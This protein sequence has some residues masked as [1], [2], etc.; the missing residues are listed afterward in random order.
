MH[1]TSRKYSRNIRTL[2]L[3]IG[4]AGGPIPLSAAEPQAEEIVVKAKPES[5]RE[6]TVVPKKAR[7]SDTASLLADEPGVAVQGAGGVSSLP[8]VHG[9]AD[10]RVLVYVDGMCLIASCPNHMN[11][12]L[13]YLDPSQVGE[14]KVYAGISPVSLGGDSIGGTIVARTPEP[15][16]ADKGER[17]VRGE[18]GSY[19]RSNGSARGGNLSLGYATD[20][21]NITYRGAIARMDDYSAGKNFK[22]TT[23]T[24][25]PGETLP[26]DVVGSTA[27][28]TQNQ[29]LGLALRN[30]DDLYDATMGYQHVPFQLYPN[31]RMDMLN[32]QA[33]RLNLHYTGKKSWG[34][35]E[36]RLYGE[37]VDH[38]MDFGKDK[39]FYYGTAPNIAPGMPMFTKSKTEGARINADIEMSKRDLLRIGAE[40]QLYRLD[41]W[42]PPSPSVLQGGVTFSG[43]AP[44]TFWNINGGKRDRYGVFSEW[45]A[46]WN[47]EWMTLLGARVELVAMDT[48]TVQGYNSV[49]NNA[50]YSEGYLVSATKF[51]ALDRKRNDVNLDLTALTRYIPDDQHTYEVGVAQKTRTPNLYERYVW[52]RNTMALVM[53]NF[54]GDGNGY[55]GNPDLKPEVA[56]TISA[57]A[58]L[59]SSDKR[60]EIKVAPYF[61]HVSD[62]ID[63]VQWNRTTNVAGVNTPGQ[64]GILKYMNQTGRLFGIDVTGLLPLGGNALGE[65]RFKGLMNYLNGRN[66]DTGSGLYNV[67]PLNVKVSVDQNI[68]SLGNTL[69]MVTVARKSD[70]ST[71]RQEL[72]TQGYTLFNWR[73]SYTMDNLRFDFGVENIFDRLYYLPLGGV[74]TGQGQ[75]MSMNP[76]TLNP[77]VYNMPFGIAVPGMGR[78]VYVGMNYGF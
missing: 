15:E 5:A 36:A 41:D 21:L 39:K 73:G 18:V 34:T 45:E 50:M 66:L 3:L 69:E 22:T 19:Y 1:T 26:L 27:Y 8:V 31:Q 23:D 61:T 70:V 62:Y 58:S 2:A 29:S 7:T 38:Y 42:W 54:V 37:R 30:D 67:M 59:H 32:N 77:P 28:E 4:I 43:M 14:L 17:T 46:R 75:T 47:P 78:S 64:F 57:S 60:M 25:R 65:W 72:A 16:F 9:L 68:G 71:P 40:A 11:P 24:G 76:A 35:L 49:A 63:A 12:P 53:N 52:S 13:S 20:N 51:N 33:Y 56:R 48:G 6:T 10:D 55:L 44:N 74:Y